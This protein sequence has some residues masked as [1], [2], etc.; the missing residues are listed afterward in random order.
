MRNDR[1]T[2]DLGLWTSAG[3]GQDH[4]PGPACP[5]PTPGVPCPTSKVHRR[6]VVMVITL[7][8]LL[9]L[10]GLVL[11]LVNL[12]TQ[13]D[14]RVN[15]QSAADATAIAGAGWMARSMNA[16]AENNIA[17]TRYLALVNVL[18][19][20]PQSAHFAH[21]EQAAMLQALEEQLARGVGSGPSALMNE[22]QDM[23]QEFRDELQEEVD[24]LE[25]VDLMLQGFDMRSVTWHN[26]PRGSN[27]QLWQAMYALDEVNQT[28]LENLGDLAQLNAVTGGRLDLPGNTPGD[29]FL[30]PIIPQLPFQRG[31]FQDFMRPVKYGILPASSDDKVNNRGPYDTVF[32]WH[33][34][35]GQ[36]LNGYSRP[37]VSQG[38]GGRGNIPIGRGAGGV[39]GGWVCTDWQYT[40]YRTWGPQRWML[41][42]VSSFN[43]SQLRNSR[44]SGWTRQ[45]AN[46]K[47]N[48][49]WPGSVDQDGV[50]HLPEDEI[51]IAE[52]REPDW[53]IDFNQAAALGDGGD[54]HETAFIVIEIKSRYPTSSGSL[55]SPG[56][57]SA[58][59]RYNRWQPRLVRRSGW[60]DPRDW[61]TH[62]TVTPIGNYGWR[63]E[64]SYQMY[65]DPDI[66][67][68]PQYDPQT[69]Q[70]IPQTVYRIDH[71]YFAGVNTGDPVDIEDPYQGF[72]PA[73]DSA[74]APSDF[75][76]DLVTPDEANRR[77]YLTCLGVARQSDRP[78][79]WPAAFFSGKPYRN[80]M[81]IAQIKVFNNHSWDL[82]TPMWH[83]QL[84]PVTEFDQWV[85][86]L[87]AGLTEPVEIPEL[88]MTDI[89]EAHQS[90]DALRSL[91]P[92]MLEH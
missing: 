77:Q 23:L 13:V 88:S 76:H 57:W 46:A 92:A 34:R 18:D 21:V 20:L 1:K 2:L 84:E 15:T 25:P 10:V 45:I 6:G 61:E 33:E 54:A 47:L 89:E 36:C 31:Q 22:I 49:L 51:E 78:Q 82:W 16:V 12:G 17:I 19:S 43:R 11:W 35:V 48:Y 69:G 58:D 4:R 40:H 24:Q 38:P 81:A 72:N 7:F 79:A 9:L 73:S 3:D 53:V 52:I 70:P 26:P 32:G 28:L 65:Y 5:R 55:M 71:Y 39:G 50:E 80:M 86:M 60:I 44:F 87:E 91:A 83:A 30:I 56:S 41:D 59:N 90:M 27:G 63:E 14:K 75:R 68:E 62:P 74:P 29:A 66:G 64:W 85:D 67:L 42:R 37:P 8:A